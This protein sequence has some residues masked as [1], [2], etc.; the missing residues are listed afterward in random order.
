MKRDIVLYVVLNKDK[1]LLEKRRDND[2]Y[3]GLWA[4]PS[5]HVEMDDRVSTLMK[6]VKE[7]TGLVMEKY[8]FLGNM[9]FES[10]DDKSLLHIFMITKFSG[11][12]KQETDEGRQ[13]KWFAFDEV[14]QNFNSGT[15]FHKVSIEVLDKVVEASERLP[16]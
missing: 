16:K 9:D 12:A 2:S 13:L 1:V 8:L 10:G 6:E 5:G 4:F 11:T 3:A 7:E 14:R 15:P